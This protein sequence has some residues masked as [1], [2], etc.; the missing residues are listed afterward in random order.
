MKHSAKKINRKQSGMATLEILIAMIIIIMAISAVIMLIFGSQTSSISSGTN[1]EAL[2]KAQTLLEDSRANARSN[3]SGVVTTAPVPDDIYTKNITVID[4][5]SF[6]KK[7]TSL[8][9]W[10]GYYVSLSTVVTDW[11]SALEGDT[12]NQ[13]LTGD[14]TNPQLLGSAD[15]G[16][17]N[18]GTDVDV[19]SQK[20]YLT[21]N[22]S[23]GSKPDFY[24]V[25]V[26]NPSLAN[27]PIL[28]SVDTGPGLAAV[29]VYGNYAYVA[30]MSTVSQLQ[31][32]DI[33]I[34][35]LPKVVA[36]LRVTP[37]GD[38]AVGNSIYYLNKKI[39]LGLTKS[40]GT[41]FNVIDV[42]NP[43]NPTLKASYE[44]NSAVNNIRVKNDVAYLAV[45]DDTST[46]GVAEQLK[47]LD[48]SQADSG[49]ISQINKLSPNPSTMSGEALYLSKDGTTLYLGE[50]GANPGHKP[51]FF[52]LNI[53]TPNNITQIN[54]KYIPTSSN[55]TVNSIIVRSNL[56][57]LWTNDTNLG[58]QIW[59][60]NNLSS[61]IPYA[62]L[63][64][65]Q[66]ASSGMDCEGNYL[67]TAQK[68]QK[69]LQII[70]PN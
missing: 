49:I 59:D 39:Y 64:T 56:A 66:T 52:T 40:T 58:F 41:E 32:I 20:A 2:Y 38:T 23:S 27:L 61:A 33:S 28:G 11:Q 12:C 54:S 65:N 24:I 1:Q 22:A 47:V 51:E 43:L 25:D 57:F 18:G 16:Q 62:A 42:S 15:V 6:T 17:N 60:L 9:S 45:P 14:W 10:S 31:V 4:I 67:Y 13:T 3:F 30:N 70:G 29:K 46:A 44:I 36:S 21:A 8:V 50:G 7:V 26:S 48:V 53:T 68:S 55:I 69:A 5:N 35:N 63:N 19:I 34:P 37:V